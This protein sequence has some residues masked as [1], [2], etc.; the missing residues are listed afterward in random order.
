ML[1]LPSAAYGPRALLFSRLSLPIY[2]FVF[3]CFG[4]ASAV[5]QER[6]WCIDICFCFSQHVFSIAVFAFDFYSCFKN[7]LFL[8][9]HLVSLDEVCECCCRLSTHISHHMEGLE[10]VSPRAPL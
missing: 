3:A 10:S 9:F 8:H 2:I 1:L 6:V 4:F 7:T 5:Y